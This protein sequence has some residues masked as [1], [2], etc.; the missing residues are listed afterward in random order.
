M[1]IRIHPKKI[2]VPK[3]DPFKYDRLD[4]KEPVEVLTHLVGSIEGSCVLAIDAAWGNGKTTFLELWSRHLR[5]NQFPVV[6]LNAWETDYTEEPFT[7]LSIELT[8]GLK[9]HA[10]KAVVNCVLEGAI[11]IGRILTPRLLRLALGIVPGGELL[12]SEIGKL[13]QSF[14]E[15]RY[16]EYKEAR[17]SVQEFRDNLQTM[18][19]KVSEGHENKPVLIMIDLESLLVSGFLENTSVS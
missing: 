7:V 9:Q 12:E 14:G 16:S 3:E 18:A 13:I 15:A 6:D 19:K 2:K 5:N 1:A 10:D 8:D 11:D 4:R 17:E